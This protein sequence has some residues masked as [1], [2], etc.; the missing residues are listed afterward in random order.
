MNNV[1]LPTEF[2]SDSEKKLSNDFINNGYVIVDIDNKNLLDHLKSEISSL[3]RS[4]FVLDETY[5]ADKLLNETSKFLKDGDLN[6][7]RLNILNKINA[8]IWF[9][10]TY[11]KLVERYLSLLVGNELVMQNKVNLSIQLPQDSSSLLNLHADTWS[12]DSPFEIVSWLPLVDCYKTKSMYILPP[13][14]TKEFHQNFSSFSH[15]SGEEIF[16]QIKDKITWIDI[17]YGSAL[18]FNQSLPHGNRINEEQ[19]SRWSMNCRFKS[20]F[21]PYDKK[22]VGDFFEPIS[23]KAVSKVGMSY[24]LPSLEK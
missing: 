11:Y 24:K 16:S 13:S 2:I 4:Y 15:L 23:L 14:K 20:V 22:Q 12:G 18:L 8:E 10:P 21:S 19:S 5:Q 1:N 7:F 17:P 9:R 3:I 6:H